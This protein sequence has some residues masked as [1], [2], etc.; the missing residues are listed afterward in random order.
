MRRKVA[1]G[2][3]K[4]FGIKADLTE[5]TAI[6]AAADP[7]V[8]TLICPPATLITAAV[9]AAK[10]TVLIGG[11]D[12]HHLPQGAFTGETSAAMLV[13]AGAT[14]VI[15]G[16]SERRRDHLESNEMVRAKAEAAIEAGLIA[17][18]CVGESL[19]Q[20][21]AGTTLVA[22]AT[23]LDGS[24]PNTSTAA[25]TIIAYEPIWAVGTGHIPTP[26]QIAEVHG[27]IRAI[28]RQRLGDEADGIRILY[29]GSVKASNAAEIFAAPDV[30]GALVGGASLKASDFA[31]I[32]AALAASA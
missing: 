23:E 1:A 25:N 26:D 27:R 18:I 7:A 21:E 15:V 31:P 4:M 9:P 8:D 13:D 17:L 10:G 14:H 29:G 5:I 20:R 3:W 12:C 30:D 16:H 2:N 32:I 22:I 6:A 24:L 11:Q 28:L 19:E